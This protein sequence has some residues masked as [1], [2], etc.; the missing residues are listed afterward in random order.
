MLWLNLLNTTFGKNQ[1]E[2]NLW[3]NLYILNNVYVLP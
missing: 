1:I 2:S 3:Q